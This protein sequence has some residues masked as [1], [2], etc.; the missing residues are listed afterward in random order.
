MNIIIHPDERL[1]KICAPLTEDEILKKE[2]DKISQ[3][4]GKLMMAKDGAGLAA[5]QVG[6]IKRIIVV[7]GRFSPNIYYNPVIAYRSNAMSSEYESCLSLPKITAKVSRHIE[8]RVICT[9]PGG[10]PKEIEAEGWDARVLQH[11]ID[12]LDG[13]EF[14]DRIAESK[15]KRL[16]E[17]YNYFQKPKK[18]RKL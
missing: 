8:V 5:P 17:K 2:Y 13:L 15:R 18:K 10:E 11:E 16:M 7:R 6:I 12:H 1:K 3:E 4:I 14:V 9:L